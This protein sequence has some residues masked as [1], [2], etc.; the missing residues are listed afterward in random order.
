MDPDPHGLRG[1]PENLAGVG[2]ERIRGSLGR[3]SPDPGR[4]GTAVEGGNRRGA[5]V[6]RRAGR[7]AELAGAAKAVEGAANARV[8]VEVEA[9]D[10]GCRRAARRGGRDQRRAE[11][12]RTAAGPAGYGG[13]GSGLGRAERGPGGPRW[14]RGRVR[15]A[16]LTTWQ[17]LVGREGREG[18]MARR[19]W[20]G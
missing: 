20:L 8:E 7:R 16:G 6:A 19:D 4:E 1:S 14:A 11:A 13:G 12:R 3:I 15:A 2:E 5:G 17:R 9:G 18:D 10:G